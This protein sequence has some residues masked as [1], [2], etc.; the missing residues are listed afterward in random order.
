MVSGLLVKT[1]FN[2]D[3]AVLA[4]VALLRHLPHVT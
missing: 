3:W 1:S 2:L 4:V